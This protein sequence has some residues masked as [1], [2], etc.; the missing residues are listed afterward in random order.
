[1]VKCRVVLCSGVW[2]GVICMVVSCVVSCDLGF[3]QRVQC[4]VLHTVWSRS[5]VDLLCCFAC[6]Y[7]QHQA[8]LD[9]TRPH[10][11]T[12]KHNTTH[13]KPRSAP[14]IAHNT[15]YTVYNAVRA[16]ASTKYTAQHEA[17]ILHMLS[18]FI[19]YVLAFRACG[20]YALGSKVV[21]DT[22]L[23]KSAHCMCWTTACATFLR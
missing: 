16:T 10:H 23:A 5:A 15:P 13:L 1:M 14:R 17:G 11:T 21:G 22:T 8:R 9:Q 12:T 20:R 4:C 2:R 7:C 6:A 18:I 3:A 19:S